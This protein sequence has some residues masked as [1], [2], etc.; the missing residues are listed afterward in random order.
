[1]FQAGRPF[2]TDA[3][4]QFLSPLALVVCAVFSFAFAAEAANPKGRLAAHVPG[5]FLVKVRSDGMG[6][7]SVKAAEGV[8][9]QA[10][11]AKS[12]GLAIESISPLRTDAR[13]QKVKLTHAQSLE[14]ALNRLNANPRIE[15]AEPNYIYQISS[16]ERAFNL[17]ND[18][19]VGQLWGMKNTGQADKSG[20]VGTPGADINVAPL[21][22]M[23]I[24]GDRRITVAIIDTGVSWT[25]PD[26]VDNLYTNPGEIAGNGIDDDGN[27]YIDDVHGWN[28]EGKSNNSTDDHDHG[29]HCAGTIGGTGNNGIGVAGVNWKVSLMPLKFLSASG[30]G[31][32]DDAVDAIN[33]ATMM[34]VNVMSNSWGGGGFSQTMLDAITRAKDAGILFVAAA[35]NA[36]S[37]NDATPTY[38]SNYVVDNVLSVGA[39]DNR[40]TL[41]S[42]SCFGK[43]TVHVAA[44]GNWIL[45]SVKNGGYD[46]FRGTSMATPHVAGIAA[47]LLSA[48]PEWG[49]AE[50]KDR[51][52]RSSPKLETLKRKVKSGGRVDAYNAMMGIFPPTN[53]PDES[54]WQDVA[55]AIETEHPYKE[56]SDLTFPIEVEGAKFVRVVFDRIDLE[57]GYDKVWLENSAG[58]RID[59]LSGRSDN[60]VSE[61]F[62]GGSGRIRFSSDSSV[63]SW[64]F[65]IT[66]IQVIR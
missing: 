10:L 28:F 37:N 65:S 1:M 53:E 44:P 29:S 27:G 58:D 47:L 60:Y 30:S 46:L 38:P 52:I 33:Y 15:Y 57:Q 34:H 19:M 14:A 24:T 31:S 7:M 63:S 8:V 9:R 43:R 54:A 4:K 12:L 11:S 66:R 50:L 45:S 20:Q 22:E 42:F 61:Y 23:G 16:Y 64:G 25:H 3:V 13:I 56:D 49:F 62:E 36:S 40:D 26:L 6:M 55:F 2:G 41:A 18:E 17:P 59:E 5:E 39:T 35:G 32:L 51:L 21:W 48:H